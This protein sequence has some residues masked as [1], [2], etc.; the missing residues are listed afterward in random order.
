[1]ATDNG[2]GA[3]ATTLYYLLRARY[4]NSHINSYDP[5]QWRLKLFTIIFQYG[6]T[7]ARRMQIQY[8]LRN[9]T[10]DELTKGNINIFNN[11]A[12][13]DTEPTTETWQT[14]NGINSQS[15]TLKKRGKLDAL[16]YLDDM[17]RT[18]L[19]GEFL[20]RFKRLF[21]QVES[22]QAPLVY[23]GVEGYDGSAPVIGVNEQFGV[24]QT[25]T[26]EDM[27]P[28]VEEFLEDYQGTGIPVTIP[29]S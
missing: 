4:S 20:D 23:P 9:M 11:A 21:L 7:W 2:S 26:F 28:T 25:N 29:I 3:T 14:L 1:M 16:A 5:Y 18:D 10:D 13:P 8:S 15:A 12:N 6:P 17:L 27:Y 22:P 24:Y 19:T